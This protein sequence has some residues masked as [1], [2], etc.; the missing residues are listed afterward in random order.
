MM[1][2]LTALVAAQA[3]G[4]GMTTVA[5]DLMSGVERR[6]AVVV[7]DETAWL[8]VWREHAGDG[9]PPAVD[10]RTQTVLAV[11]LGTKTSGGYDV[12][13]TGVRQE[14][15]ATVVTWVERRPAPGQVA[16]M[17]I[18]SPAHLVAVPKIAGEVRFEPALAEAPPR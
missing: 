12:T 1:W 7:Q 13:I 5:H 2:I 8:R 3:G 16:A 15:G 9:L 11:F 6:Q 14:G 18:T 17:V 10:F 4:A